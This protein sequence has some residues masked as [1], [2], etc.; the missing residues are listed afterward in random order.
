MEFA[1][2]MNELMPA[3][4]QGFGRRQAS[5]LYKGKITIPQ[6]LL[7]ELLNREGES[8]MTDM[9]RLMHVSTAAMT[10]L[11]D[12][13][14]LH[15]YVERVYDPGDRRIIKIKLTAAGNELVKKIIT[16][17]RSMIVNIFGALSRKDRDDYLRIM[18][19]VE[20]V[21]VKE[22]HNGR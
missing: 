15:G 19:Q 7:L 14:I 18:K 22:G 4:M 6:A 9:A 12:R 13:M 3:V 10:G 5:E 21:L 17:R 16:R 11:V 1:D 2:T 20:G 8:R